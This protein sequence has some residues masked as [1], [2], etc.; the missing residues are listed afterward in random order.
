MKIFPGVYRFIII[1]LLVLLIT[2]CNGMAEADVTIWLDAPLPGGVVNPGEEVYIQT[3][4]YSRSGVAQIELFVDGASFSLES[5]GQSG[6]DFVDLTQT[7]VANTP[8]MHS[9]KVVAYST[10]GAVSNPALV[11]IRVAGG[12]TPRAAELPAA[13][14][15][16]TPGMVTASP[17]IP[18]TPTS[19]AVI[20]SPT[21]TQP[22]PPPSII[23]SA[24][25]T[26]LNQGDCTYL[27][28]QVQNSERVTLDGSPVSAVDALRVCPAQTTNYALLAVSQ[29]G[30]RS[31]NVLVQVNI[32]PPAD[33]TGPAISNMAVNPGEIFDNAS[34][35]EDQARITAVIKDSGSG[36]KKVQLHYQVVKPAS[37]S[38]GIQYGQWQS[39]PMAGS[40]SS[41]YEAYLGPAELA[42]SMAL[43]GG[44]SVNFYIL[45]TDQQGNATQSGTGSF[46]A[47]TCIF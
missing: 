4:A 3:H 37:S 8:G 26:T 33:V 23:F 11:M 35:G 32:P 43:Y 2:G 16:I 18:V 29:G 5:P 12:E 36:V 44:G 42:R 13:E 20:I 19:T 31:Q 40:E 1:I 27:R 41:G 38:K 45:A 24:D 47:K 21:L 9:I 34:C 6:A 7:W 15:P 46:A 39:V 22:P 17:V 10:A 30:E 28:W 14:N 25:A